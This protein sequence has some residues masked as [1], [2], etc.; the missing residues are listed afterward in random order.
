MRYPLLKE[1]YIY[2]IFTKSIEGYRIF[3]SRAH[4]E[5]FIE[6]LKFYLYSE[7]PTKFSVYLRLKDKERFFKTYM[8]NKPALVDILAYCLM[9]T[10]VHLLLVQLRDRGI[11]EYMKRVLDSYS[12]Y[13]NIKTNRKG[14]L[15]Q[16]RFKHVLVETEEQL[17]H[18]TRY[19]HLNPTTDHLVEQPE[20]WQFS[21]YREYL[22]TSS[23]PLC[24]KDKYLE[25]DPEAYKLF[26]DEQIEYQQALKSARLP[27]RMW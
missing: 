22:G 10:H 25:I 8:G 26:V 19:I 15:W 5:R 14:P 13:F 24:Q 11:S 16:S 1:G 23:M 17:M 12:K 20:D 3:K 27:H 21:S 7:P 9:P 6:T 4:Y 18:T 2:H